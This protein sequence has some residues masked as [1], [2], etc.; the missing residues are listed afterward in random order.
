MIIVPT[1]TIPS[2]RFSFVVNQSFFD[3]WIKT[4]GEFLLVDITKDGAEILSGWRVAN[5]QY[6]LPFN[7]LSA[8]SGNFVFLSN[9][10][11]SYPKWED[12]NLTCFLYYLENEE[13]ASVNSS[14]KGVYK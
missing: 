8:N 5:G 4:A 9:P 10:S 7:S 11:T 12:L 2:Q 13:V 1:E 3:F 6:L 14:R